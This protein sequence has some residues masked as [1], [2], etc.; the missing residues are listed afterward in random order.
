M[1]IAL[2]PLICG[3]AL[4]V[5]CDLDIL[6]AVAWFYE[7]AEPDLDLDCWLMSHGV[8]FETAL[9]LAGPI[10]PFSIHRFPFS[11]EFQFAEHGEP[12]AVRAAVH[13]VTGADAEKPIGLVGW[14]RERPADV[15]RIPGDIAALGLDQLAN[16]ASYVV[17]PLPVHRSPLEWLSAD[18]RGIVPLD[19][20]AMWWTLRDLPSRPGGY[21]LAARSIAHGC[22][23]RA[24]LAWASG[25]PLP[26]GVRLVVPSLEAAA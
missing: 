1:T 19:L 8:D 10:C 14:T 21:P 9:R 15:Y 22:D 2:D 13:V 16:P 24:D 26:G 12:G 5:A 25:A 20:Q 11:R 6:E 3:T 18:C 17:G 4:P 7:N 23:L